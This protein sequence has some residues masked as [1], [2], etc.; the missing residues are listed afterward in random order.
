M[1]HAAKS[2]SKKIALPY[3]MILTKLFRLFDVD[4]SNQRVDNSCTVFGLKNVH[5]MK[6]ENFSEESV[7]LG[8]RKR[9]VFEKDGLEMLSDAL[10]EQTENILQSGTSAGTNIGLNTESI[11]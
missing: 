7:D 8:K 9:E 10:G 5:H 3:G 4:E 6:K 11:P 2:G 1:I